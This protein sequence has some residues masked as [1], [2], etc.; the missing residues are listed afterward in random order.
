MKTLFSISA[1]GGGPFSDSFTL[2]S[3]SLEKLQD[4]IF[5]NVQRLLNPTDPR[6]LDGGILLVFYLNSRKR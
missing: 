4:I 2:C 6:A 3:H 5:F 1:H